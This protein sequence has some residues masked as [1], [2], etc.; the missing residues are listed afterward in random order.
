[1]LCLRSSALILL[2]PG[3]LCPLTN[4]SPTAPPSKL[5][6][7]LGL[8]ELVL[9]KLDSLPEKVYFLSFK[10]YCLRVIFDISN[11]SKERSE[12]LDG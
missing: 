2:R 6:L 10:C 1:M 7:G 11:A 4:V 8:V 9:L 12:P 5:L 3:N